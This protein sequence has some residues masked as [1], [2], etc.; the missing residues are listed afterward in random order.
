MNTVKQS[1]TDRLIGLESWW[2]RLLDVQRPY[3]THLRR[4]KLGF[5]LDIGCGLGRNLINLGG[6]IAG[7]GIDHNLHSIAV[8]NGRGLTAFTPEEFEGTDYAKEGRFD[9]ILLSHVAE[10]MKREEVINLLSKYL[11]Y[12]HLGGR[13]VFVTPQEQGFRSDPTHVMFM[14]FEALAAIAKDAGLTM[15]RQYSFPFP[16]VIGH[17]FK[18]N[19]FITICHKP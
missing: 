2:K 14:D 19:E 13:V 4:L 16:R 3:R 8:A 6:S 9:T 7:V 15:V 17:I 10:H 18:Y 1:Y 5:V 11:A 12:L